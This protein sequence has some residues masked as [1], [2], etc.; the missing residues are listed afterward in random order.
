VEL[1][2]DMRVDRATA[3]RL[4]GAL[5]QKGFLRRATEQSATTD[6]VFEPVR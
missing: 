2:H 5:I 4:I 6:E 3:D 1:V